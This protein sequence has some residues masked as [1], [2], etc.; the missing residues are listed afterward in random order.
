M[1]VVRME[2]V[3]QRGNKLTKEPVV[4]LL[5]RLAEFRLLRWR[6]KEKAT[7]L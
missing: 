1:N 7:T 6:K 4:K 3:P 2:T 5:F